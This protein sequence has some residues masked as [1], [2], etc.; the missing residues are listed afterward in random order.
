LSPY[1]TN[2]AG[3]KKMQDITHSISKNNQREYLIKKEIRNFE[4]SA[5]RRKKTRTV[6]GK[7]SQNTLDQQFKTAFRKAISRQTS[8][9]D[10][11]S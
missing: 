2:E 6:C 7:A 11:P 3:Q 8:P 10:G 4:Q 1:I 9:E 5:E